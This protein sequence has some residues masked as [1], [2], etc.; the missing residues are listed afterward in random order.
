M[1]TK[2]HGSSLFFQ[3]PPH[4]TYLETSHRARIHQ[5]SRDNDGLSWPEVH[6]GSGPPPEC[7]EKKGEEEIQYITAASRS[8]AC[9]VRQSSHSPPSPL[10]PRSLPQTVSYF[11]SEGGNKRARSSV[12]SPELLIERPVA[13]PLNLIAASVTPTTPPRRS[14]GRSDG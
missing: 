10:L 7:P 6:K 1:S 5:F 2:K 8:E 11:P 4:I 12:G 14:G 9:E 13:P 3:L